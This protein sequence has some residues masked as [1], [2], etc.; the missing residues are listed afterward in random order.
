ME[1]PRRLFFFLSRAQ[2]KGGVLT[3]QSSARGKVL[4]YGEVW[5]ATLPRLTDWPQPW[6]LTPLRW[7]R[8]RRY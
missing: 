3:A 8:T 4:I 7:E 2:S 6:F 5:Y 1:E